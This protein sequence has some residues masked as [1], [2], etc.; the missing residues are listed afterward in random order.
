MPTV[1]TEPAIQTTANSSDRGA[2]NSKTTYEVDRSLTRRL[3][4]SGGQR[5]FAV[6]CGDLFLE[7]RETTGD[8]PHSDGLDET[9][10]LGI[11]RSAVHVAGNDIAKVGARS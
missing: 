7:L 11:L 5:F 1:G 10:S 4:P 9:L 3:A 6:D 8:A 2:Q